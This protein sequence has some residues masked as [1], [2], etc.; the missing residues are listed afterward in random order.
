MSREGKGCGAESGAP[1]GAQGTQP[2]EK[3]AGEPS[4]SGGVKKCV[5]V[6]LGLVSLMI[7]EAFPN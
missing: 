6:A 7:S 2:G 4:G 3:E 5:D 1:G